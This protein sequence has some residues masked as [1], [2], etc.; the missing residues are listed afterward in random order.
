MIS[1]L[2]RMPPGDKITLSIIHLQTGGLAICKL[3]AALS[4]HVLKDVILFARAFTGTD[5]TFAAY[6]R[7]KAHALRFS[8]TETR[9][10]SR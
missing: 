6:R 4:L 8:E 9:P 3:Q 1:L 10:Q 5:T 7:G 2:D